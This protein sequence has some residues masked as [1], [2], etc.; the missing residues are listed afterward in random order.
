[1]PGPMLPFKSIESYSNL[2]VTTHKNL[3]SS[4]HLLLMVGAANQNDRMIL[5]TVISLEGGS[6]ICL[7]PFPRINVCYASLRLQEYGHIQVQMHV[8]ACS[9]CWESSSIPMTPYSLRQGH[10]IKLSIH[11]HGCLLQGSLSL[12]SEA[13]NY[14]WISCLLGI[15]MGPGNLSCDLHTCM[16]ST[17]TT[18]PFHRSKWQ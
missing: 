13:Q 14:R 4:S 16:A 10:S 8:A 2:N 9:I 7:F 6:C 3:R 12:S 15:C 5:T 18:E 1:M 11:G 17:L